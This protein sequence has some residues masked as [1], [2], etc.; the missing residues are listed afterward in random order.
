MPPRTGGGHLL[1]K[2][3]DSYGLVIAQGGPAPTMQLFTNRVLDPAHPLLGHV[4]G[5]S[6]LLV[7][8]ASDATLRSAAG[9]AVTSWAEHLEVSR[10]ELLDM[11]WR[12]CSS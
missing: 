10:E 1:Q 6:Q 7:P 9:R 3:F 4:D 12:V 2:L 8:Y 5:R 11:G